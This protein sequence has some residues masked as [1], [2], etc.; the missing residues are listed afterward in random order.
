MNSNYQQTT[1]AIEEITPETAKQWLGLNHKNRRLSDPIIT[2]LAGIIRRDEW[3]PDSTDGIGLD[4][5]GGVINGQHR[6]NAV[7]EA[8]K[9]IRA[10]VVRNVRPEV[11]K[12]IDQ[13]RGRTFTQYLQMM[14]NIIQPNVT[15]P[16]VEWLYRMNHGLEVAMPTAL[17][18]TVPQLLE[19]FG[20][21]RKITQSVEPAHDAYRRVACPTKPMLAAYHY[22][23]ASVDAELADDFFAGLASGVDLTE[24]SPVHALREKYLKENA[25]DQ[26]RKARAYVLA[27]WLVKAWEATRQGLELTERQLYWTTSGRKGEPFPKVTELPWTVSDDAIEPDDDGD[28]DD[29]DGS[30]DLS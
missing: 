28:G 1:C 7:I 4:T 25:K 10:L 5:D 27:A 30:L 22:A 12:V 16:A 18:P 26:S 8:D 14:E 2:R 11:I 19:T 21:H 15:A 20:E 6:L 3:M 9:P 23:M 13:G 29:S 17:K 24:R